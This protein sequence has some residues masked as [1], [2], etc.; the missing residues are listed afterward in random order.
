ML[1]ADD[2]ADFETAL[3]GNHEVEDDQVREER[4]RLRDGFFAVGGSFDDVVLQFEVVL[5]T[6]SDDFFVF[7]DEYFV[8]HI[9]QPS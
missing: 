8:L 6:E 7:D 3:L 1:L 4:V 5:E 9:S 2:A